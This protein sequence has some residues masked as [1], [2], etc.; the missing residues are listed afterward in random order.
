MKTF[1][2]MLIFVLV[3]CVPALYIPDMQQA[4][5]AGIRLEE[6]HRGR[7]LYVDHCGSCHTLY[8]PREFSD[9]AWQRLT[10]SM[11]IRSK[12]DTTQRQLILRYLTS[13]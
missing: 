7:Q 4:D 9:T 12:I 11:Q 1:L 10:V 8:L 6:L 3:A 13:E 5:K 2:F